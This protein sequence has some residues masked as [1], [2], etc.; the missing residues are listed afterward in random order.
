M[1]AEHS[2][3]FCD[4]CLRE[5]FGGEGNF[6]VVTIQAVADPTPPHFQPDQRTARDLQEEIQALIQRMGEMS[7]REL[8]DQVHRRLVIYLCRTC[9]EAWIENPT[10][11]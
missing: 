8:V 2:P 6:Y 3:I 1:A 7:E 11:R 10:S 5:L 9:F 4:R